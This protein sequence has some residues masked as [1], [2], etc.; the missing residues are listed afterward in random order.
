VDDPADH[1]PVINPVRP[2]PAARQQRL[3]PLPFLIA[4]PI[5]L[6]SHQGLPESEALNHNSLRAGILRVL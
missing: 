5:E 4:Q 2:T 6:L 1:A 3:D